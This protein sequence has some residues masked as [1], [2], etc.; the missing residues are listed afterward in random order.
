[1]PGT[2]LRFRRRCTLQIPRW[3][4]E[5]AMGFEPTALRLGGMGSGGRSRP[6]NGGCADAIDAL[7]PLPPSVPDGNLQDG[8]RKA[9]GF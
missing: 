1:M 3:G 9:L 5:R 2:T 4:L 7:R 8:S 6:P